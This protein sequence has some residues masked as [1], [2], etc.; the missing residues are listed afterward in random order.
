MQLGSHP[1]IVSRIWD[2]LGNSLPLDCKAIV[3]GNP[4]LVN[5][6]NGII[7]ALGYGTRYAIRIPEKYIEAAFKCG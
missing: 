4:A 3:Y 6:Q 7:L 5:P 1:D 2:E